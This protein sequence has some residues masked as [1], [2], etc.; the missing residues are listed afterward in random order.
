L[1]REQDISWVRKV[2]HTNEADGGRDLI[3][4][5]R[6]GPLEKEILQKGENPFKFRKVIVQCKASN[7][8][9]GKA[10]VKDIRDTIEQ[11]NYD[12]Y[13]LAVSSHLKRNLTDALDKMR[14]DGHYWVN[15]WSRDEIEKRLTRHQDLVTKYSNIITLSK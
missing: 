12:G 2:S 4:N 6:T 14:N 7:V 11:F 8:G 9:I 5:W 13:F 3:A 15:W 10:E 1:E